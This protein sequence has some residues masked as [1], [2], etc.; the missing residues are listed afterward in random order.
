M[1]N[2]K[3]KNPADRIANVFGG[4]HG[5]VYKVQRNPFFTKYFLSVSDWATRIWNEDLREA[6]ILWTKYDQSYVMDA[7]WS[8]SRPAVYMTAKASGA[9]DIWDLLFKTNEPTLSLKI[10]DASLSS[11][12]VESHGHMMAVG[13]KDGSLTLVELGKSLAVA[14]AGEKHALA[15]L[16]ER[17]TGREKILASRMRELRLAHS[18]DRKSSA[19]PTTGH[20]QQA[21][22]E[23]EE[24]PVKAA[25][26]AFWDVMQ[27]EQDRQAALKAK[28]EASDATATAETGD[29]E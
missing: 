1:G 23:E 28:A 17:E 16:F 15:S 25:E 29:D 5:P 4:H 21:H 8:P 24:D 9:V 13:A 10:S 12:A 14:S 18:K 19:R 27:M 11:L 26:K 3:A 22:Q 2:R 6:P 7:T 20:S